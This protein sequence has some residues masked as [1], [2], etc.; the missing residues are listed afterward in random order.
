MWKEYSQKKD[1]QERERRFDRCSLCARELKYH[2]SLF[3]FL[4]AH[5][6]ERIFKKEAENVGK[7]GKEKRGFTIHG[8]EFWLSKDEIEKE[9]GCPPEDVDEIWESGEKAKV[10][11]PTKLPS[12]KPKKKPTEKQVLAEMKRLAANGI[13]EVHSRL[14]SDKLGLDPDKGRQQVR[15]LM[16]KLEKTGRVVI[17]KKTVKEK[18]ARKRYVYRLVK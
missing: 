7:R 12:A 4:V 13:V 14:V 17:E 16:K 15:V 2:L 1:C 9:F 8:R 18:G 6:L 11:K 5:N 10:E 3:L